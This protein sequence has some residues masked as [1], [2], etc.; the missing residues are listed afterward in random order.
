MGLGA[1]V[2]SPATEVIGDA[3]SGEEE[4]E[5]IA[6]ALLP[7]PGVLGGAGP[8][9]DV[10][11]QTEAHVFGFWAVMVY[12][13]AECTFSDLLMK[14]EGGDGGRVGVGVGVRVAP[15]GYVVLLRH[16]PWHHAPSVRR[17][18]RACALATT[19]QGVRIKGSRNIAEKVAENS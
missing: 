13:K 9:H 2:A 3:L 19:T 16:V 17:P 14:V 1:V 18:S 5:I 15:R 11:A 10:G 6:P 7:T 4:E 8:T 12:Q